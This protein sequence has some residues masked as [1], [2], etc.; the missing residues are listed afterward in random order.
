MDKIYAITVSNAVEAVAPTSIF[1]LVSPRSV[2]GGIV[3]LNAV[4]VSLVQAVDADRVFT[5]ST[6]TDAYI[7]VSGVIR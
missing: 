3:T 6:D 1:K 4:Q 7:V 2:V 5:A